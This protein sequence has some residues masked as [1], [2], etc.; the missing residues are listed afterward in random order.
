MDLSVVVASLVMLTAFVGLIVVINKKNKKT[1][2]LLLAATIVSANLVAVAKAA[3]QVCKDQIKSSFIYAGV[4]EV[5]SADLTYIIKDDETVVQVDPF[6]YYQT[7]IG[8]KPDEK[9]CT[10]SST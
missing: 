7:N 2:A 5:Y 9:L 6:N 3:S 4:E 8:Y 1:I 10:I